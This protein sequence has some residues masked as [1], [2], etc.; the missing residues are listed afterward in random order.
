MIQPR[1][2][3]QQAKRLI[4][5]ESILSVIARNSPRVDKIW[6]TRLPQTRPPVRR[7]SRAS[8]PEFFQIA[9]QRFISFEIPL[10]ANS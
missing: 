6:T 9:A 5:F 1:P 2:L 7:S 10:S 8:F 4:N 3:S